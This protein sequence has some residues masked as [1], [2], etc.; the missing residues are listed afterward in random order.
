MSN[1]TLPVSPKKTKVVKSFTIHP[2]LYEAARV[3][4]AKED[5][6]FSY[7]VARAIARDLAEVRSKKETGSR[8]AVGL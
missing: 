1:N 4:A 3:A 2:D 5:R 8:I 6:N 7:F